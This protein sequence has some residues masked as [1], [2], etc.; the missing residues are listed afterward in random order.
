MLRRDRWM[1]SAAALVIAGVAS[2][3][4]MG[5]RAALAEEPAKLEEI[6]GSPLKRVVL[7]EKAA[8]RLAIATEPVREE[9]V[10]RWMM[11]NGEVEAAKAGLTVPVAA[12]GAADAAPVLVRVPLPGDQAGAGGQATL[13]LS[14]VGKDQGG[15]GQGGQAPATPGS[16]FV[17]PSG[18]D[19]RAPIPARPAGMPGDA[20]AQYYEVG[21][22]AGHGLTPGQGVHVGVAQPG[23]GAPH[24]VIPYSAVFYDAHGNVWAYTNPEPLVFVRQPVDVEHI[25]GDVAVLKEGS[26]VSGEVVTAGAA[27]LWGIESEFG[28]GH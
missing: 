17:L 9:P 25:E 20:E 6:P 21:D 3:G 4:G 1:V 24:K 7:T 22:T 5:G 28:G 8:E 26:T 12:A 16:A 19:D 13:V 11:V 27:E 14:L 18:A 2:S 10:A 15:A 23:S